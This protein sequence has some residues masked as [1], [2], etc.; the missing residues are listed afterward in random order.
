[1]LLAYG[2]FIIHS[3][4]GILD[5]FFVLLDL[6]AL[7]SAEVVKSFMYKL[8]QPPFQFSIAVFISHIMREDSWLEEPLSV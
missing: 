6:F 4:S 8:F 7:P 5:H 1:M 2:S 3:M